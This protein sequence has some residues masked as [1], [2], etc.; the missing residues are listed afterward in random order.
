MLAS[1]L[2]CLWLTQKS[3]HWTG[4]LCTFFLYRRQECLPVGCPPWALTKRWPS[5]WAA[6][7]TLASP[8][9]DVRWRLSCKRLVLQ[10]FSV[11]C[12][13]I[14]S[15]SHSRRFSYVGEIRSKASVTDSSCKYRKSKLLGTMSTGW[16]SPVRYLWS[17]HKLDTYEQ[18]SCGSL[19]KKKTSYSHHTHFSWQFWK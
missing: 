7:A 13:R 6:S 3:P 14:P 17:V 11:R 9:G 16:F 5:T 2:L 15:R 12:L 18:I 10:S 8:W 4:S 1:A 19:L